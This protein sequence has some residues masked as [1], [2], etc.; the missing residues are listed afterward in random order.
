MSTASQL[1]NNWV[2]ENANPSPPGIEVYFSKGGGYRNWAKRQKDPFGGLLTIQ[3]IAS[4][5]MDRLLLKDKVFEL[6][7]VASSANWDGEGA[8]PLSRKTVSYATQ[9]VDRL[10]ETLPQ[11]DVGASPHG[12]IDFEWTLSRETMLSVSMCPDGTIAFA[13]LF[14]GEKTRSSAV[15]SEEIPDSLKAALKRLQQATTA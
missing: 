7:N 5:E 15:W 10:P 2:P 9:F 13:A 12:M 4:T 3:G 14:P 1:A 11:P 8:V 6:Q